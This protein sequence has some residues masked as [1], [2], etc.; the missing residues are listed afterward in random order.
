MGEPKDDRVESHGEAGNPSGE[1]ELGLAGDLGLSSERTDPRAA[2][3]ARAPAR[4]HRA[5][6]MAPSHRARNRPTRCTGSNRRPRRTPPSC[7]PTT[8]SAPPTRT[9]AAPTP[10][11]PGGSL[12]SLLP[13][14]QSRFTV[15]PAAYVVFLRDDAR[16]QVLLQLRRGTGYMDE[17][18]ACAA[19]G[20]VEVGETV[21]EAAAPRGH[22][23]GRRHRRRARPPHRDAAHQRHRSRRRRARRL[24]LHL[25]AVVRLSPHRRAGQVRRPALVPARRHARP[26]RPARAR[27]AHR[28]RATGT[29]PPFLSFGF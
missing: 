25:R 8:T 23:G 20:H 14:T 27:R 1:S 26:R 28:S 29:L 4:P 9:L 19:A 17:H 11:D 16:A 13:M 7:P 21:H 22:R 18:W 5:A 10:E 24:L 3:R 15:V 6:P 2:S 12:A